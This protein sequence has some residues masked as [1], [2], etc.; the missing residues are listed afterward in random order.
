M[1]ISCGPKGAVKKV[2][3][4]LRE[5]KEM[6]ANNMFDKGPLARTYWNILQLNDKKTNNLHEKIGKGS[7]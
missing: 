1:R 6:F 4:Q 7:E 3:R 5:W 2:R